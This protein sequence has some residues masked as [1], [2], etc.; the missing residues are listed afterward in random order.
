MDTE[1]RG[2]LADYLRGSLGPRADSVLAALD[3]NPSAHLPYHGTPHIL[4][5]ALAVL[6]LAADEGLSPAQT[7]QT[8]LAAVFHDVDYA[9]DPDDSVNI[10]RAVAAAGECLG[11][12]MDVEPVQDLIRATC[13]PHRQAPRNTME[14]VLRDA[15]V[16]FSSLL[17]PDAQHFRTGLLTERGAP[18]GETDAIA[19]ILGHGVNTASAARRINDFVAAIR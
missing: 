1:R 19:F 16:A 3:A 15:D 9:G 13:F 7:L 10:E 4:V 8:V 5:V 11:A 2:K 18:A 17:V 6:E 14:A 12:F